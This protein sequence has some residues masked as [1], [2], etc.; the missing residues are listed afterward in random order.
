[1]KKVIKI[2]VPILL[3]LVVL[4]SICWY[5]FVY[6]RSFTQNL[7][8]NRARAADERG[9]YSAS[10]W[11]YNLAYRHSRED[12]QVAIELA[13]RFKS[14]GN[15]TKAEYTLS[16]AISDGGGAKV[17]IALCKTYVEQ[18]KLR[19]AVTMLDNIAD[20]VIKAELDAMRPKAPEA[21][22]ADGYYNEYISVSF[23]SDSGK[24]Y[25]TTE[26]DYPSVKSQPLTTP[27]K[28]EGGET[29]VHAVT[30]SENGLVSPI[31]ILGYTI[32]GV[33][34]EV[35]I[36]DAALDAIIREQLNVSSA[37]TLFSNQ[38]WN[39]TE[40]N[41]N[42]EVKDLSELSKL[43]F[44]ENLTIQQG[45]YQNLSAISALTN[46]TA[47]TI[48]GV[49]LTTEELKI[50][51]SFPD[52][53]TLSLVRCNLSG[54]TELSGTTA[55]TS[56]N[57]SNNTIRDLEPLSAMTALEYLNLSHNAITQ[58]TAL[59]GASKLKELDVSYNSIN[60]T[61]ALS[62]CKSLENL[63]LDYN[64]VTNLG[65][66]DKLSNLKIL[67]A[68][69]NQITA[70]NHL[71]AA[72]NITDLDISNNK[73]ADISFLKAHIHLKQLNFSN[74]QVS[75]L[76][77]FPK[78]CSLSS[79]NGSRNVLTDLQPLYGLK[80]LNYVVMDYNSGITSVNPLSSC[81]TLVEVSVYGTAVTDVSAL[82]KLNVIVKYAPIG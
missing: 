17:Y 9:D 41:I 68:S 20:P 5:L 12:D 50:I 81:V 16:N 13:E 51:A 23:T 15:Y 44:I 82:T 66:L 33:I 78:D 36:T 2:V 56:L 11:Y 14:I 25:V 73:I 37:H 3:V 62:G 77:A 49:T 72:T 57:L 39:I 46:L 28:L 74:N 29:K 18:D 45:K 79:I 30:V 55:L 27:L 7:L 22:P 61:A 53:R 70:I 80:E 42:S 8:L 76:P 19:D 21:S 24:V 67:S 75:V 59:S 65:G 1:M 58:L 64:A 38:L 32:A 10:A 34:E 6:D 52:L 47:L 69:N 60:S 35:T 71:A 40:L 43:P 4:S 63:Y 26:G 31:R 48:D 54:I